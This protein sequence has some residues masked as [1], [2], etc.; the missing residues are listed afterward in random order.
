MSQGATTLLTLLSNNSGL[1]PISTIISQEEFGKALRKWSEGTSTSPSGRHLGHYRCLFT[2]DGHTY[3]DDD[4][5]PSDDIMGVYY[6]IA[7]AAL[8]W[9]IT[10]DRWH[11]SITTM[12]EK[13]PGCSRINKLRVIHLYEADYNLLLKI[14]W[15][16]RLV[17]HA[18][19]LNKLNA[20]Q[21]G[22][23]PGRNSI[24][25]VI[26]KEMKYLYATLTRTGLATMDNDAKSCYD[27]IICN[28]AMMVS[29]YFG[30]SREAASMQAETLQKMI[31]RIRTAI[32]DSQRAYRHSAST[33]IHGTGQ[34]SCASPAIWLLVCSSLMD[35][36]SK[37]GFGMTLNDVIG[38]RTLR[39]LIEGFVDD[40]S[41]F[42]NLLRTSIDRNDIELLTTRL[43]HDMIAW[44]EL[45]EASGGKLELTKCFYYIL[46]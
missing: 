33:P 21:A 32:R 28:L 26:Q 2:D 3:T 19:D 40:T 37:L 43:Q 16:R 44:K 17:W 41:L 6:N 31:F 24:D 45:L 42:T 23:I 12:I 27:R 18:H 14:I 22:L 15:A 10:L 13:Q 7:T 38:K 36:L 8:G 34:G 29:Q 46:S 9:G 20:G 5:D 35:C 39:Q 1:P 11:N 25:V 30:V 4:P